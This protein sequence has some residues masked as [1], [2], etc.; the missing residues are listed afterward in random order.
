MRSRAPFLLLACGVALIAAGFAYDLSFAGL[1]YQDPTPQMQERWL[2]HKRVAEMIL[3]PGLVLLGVGAAWSGARW[4][5][6]MSRR[7]PSGS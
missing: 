4:I 5:M 2:F 1:P 3:M 6:R 7:N